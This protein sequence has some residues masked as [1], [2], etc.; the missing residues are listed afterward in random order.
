MAPRA[1]ASCR[2]PEPTPPEAPVTSTRSPAATRPVQHVLAREIG[3]A[4]GRELD[5]AQLGV[6]DMRIL[7]RHDDIFR[8][9]AIAAVADIVDVGEAVVVA[10]VD[11]EIDHHPLADSRGATPA[12]TPT[13]RPAMSA[14]WMRGKVEG[15]CLGGRL[16]LATA[17]G[18]LLVP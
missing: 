1:R 16:Q 8:I 18:G 15:R 13:I 6:D 9:T 5:I 4:K 14:P 3:A 7:G 2:I 11:A 17:A 12:P 10:V